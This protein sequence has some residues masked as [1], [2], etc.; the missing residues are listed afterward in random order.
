VAIDWSSGIVIAELA[1][2]PALSDEL[3]SLGDRVDETPESELPAV[4]LNFAD[5]T[6]LNSSNIAQLLRIRRR[7]QD[8][9][10]PLR[11]CSVPDPVWSIMLLTGLDKVFEFA[12]DPATAIASIQIDG[13]SGGARN[14][15]P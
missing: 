4:V 1:D 14:A 5:V 6:Y 13:G 9:E 2:E 10:K 12:P 8:G 3:G 11:L 15:G 7:L